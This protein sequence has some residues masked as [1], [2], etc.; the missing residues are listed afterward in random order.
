MTIPANYKQVAKLYETL[1]PKIQE[2]IAHYPKL[3][4][5]KTPLEV[6]VA[7]LFQRVE[8]A[9]RRALYGG[10]IKKFSANADLTGEILEKEHLT[11]E[12]FDD[13]IKKIFDADVPVSIKAFLEDAEKIRDKSM[14]GG[15]VD[16]PPLRKA[17][18]DILKYLERIK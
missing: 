8:R 3:F 9:H 1:P 15:E 14:H 11:R 18:Q 7:Y 16:E 2:Y 10:I 4:K 13:L 5:A 6:A 17:I 12:G